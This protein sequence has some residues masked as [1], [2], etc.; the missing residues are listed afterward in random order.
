MAESEPDPRQ[1]RVALVGEFPPPAAGMTIQAEMLRARLCAAGYAVS[2]V[3]TNAPLPAWLE[4]VRGVRALAR[5]GWFLWQCRRLVGAEVVHVFACSGLSFLLF[6]APPVWFGRLLR[7]RV[8]LHYHGGALSEFAARH[9]WLLGRTVAAA[10]R[11]VV[12][13][14]FLQEVFSEL[15]HAADVVGNPAD[16][17]AFP[18]SPR[19]AGAPVVLSCRNLEPVYDVATSLRAFAELHRTV[20]Q[21][22]LLVAGDGSLRRDLETLAGALGLEE[23]V[24]FLG[25]VPS[26]QMPGLLARAHV[27]IN[28]TRADNLPGS[29]LEAFAA[30]VPVVS[31]DAGGIPWLVRHETNGLLAP[32]GDAAALACHLARVIDDPALARELAMHGRE[33]AVGYQWTKI[34]PLWHAIYR[35]QPLPRAA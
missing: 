15:G 13:S 33:T 22:R 10:D 14:G 2:S 29:I 18:F 23:A 3:R 26:T 20:P 11:L 5:W 28:S 17:R 1:G 25:N 6:A 27:L 24:S 16:L 8:V 31:T 7:R 19:P 34:E 4:G 21:A 30:G 9:P 35:G 12:P 32:V